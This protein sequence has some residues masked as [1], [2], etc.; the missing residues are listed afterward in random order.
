MK[1]SGG[2]RSALRHRD[3]RL[4]MI[5]FA[6]SAAGSWAYNV[7]LAVYV[8]EQTKSP[9]WVGA[10]TLARLIPALIAGFYGGVIAERFERVR[11]MVVL[12]LLS[13][14]M[15]I[16]LAVA[17]F[18][19][20]PVLLV[21]VIAPITSIIGTAYE[22][23][24]AAITPQV[25]SE[26]DLAAANALRNVVDNLAV[27]AGPAIGVL[28]LLLGPPALGFAV[29]AVSFAISALVVARVRTRSRPVDVTEDGTI[30]P[31]GQMLVGFRTIR[32]SSAATILVAYSVVA[33]FVY[34]VDTVLFVVLSQQQL[35]TGPDGF[36]Y[37]LAGLGAGGVLAAAAVSRLSERP[38][39]GWI[40]LAG[41]AVY[42][43]PTLAFL[44]V[45]Q[46]AVGFALQVIRGAGTLVVDVL[47]I[48]ALQRTMP[49]DAMARVFGA[50]DSLMVGAIALGALLTPLVLAAAGLDT[51]LIVSGL[52]VPV[53]CVI[54]WPRLRRMDEA[55]AAQIAEL[56]PR[57]LLLERVPILAE[58]PRG[59]IERL[60]RAA[61]EIEVPA[62]VAIV[63]EGEAADAF[64]VVVSGD[65]LVT[66]RGEGDAERQ[67]PQLSTGDYFG[68]IG[69]LEHIPRTATV[70]TASPTRLLRIPGE[71][72]LD[73]LTQRNPSPTLLEG[74]RIRL[75]RTH[76]TYRPHSEPPE[77]HP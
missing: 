54:G 55:D 38:R 13:A 46:P 41:M 18:V 60:A 74:A 21:L 64:F 26:R 1:K 51:A 3:F 77:N 69:L 31:L 49:S 14:L 23:A 19:E 32:S 30:G 2:L 17:T 25:V 62:G 12:D 65:V 56:A 36:G 9:A 61:E 63:T 27:I 72:F 48:T 40:I 73:A 42:C 67:L 15:M 11:L 10:A 6:T 75:A 16:T 57:V 39:L 76:P 45:D 29:N 58:A 44:V 47:A 66:A 33:T 7:A 70:T 50:F 28:L 24:V 22:P 8:Y 37:L 43:L 68:E 35:G 34:G 20:A 59:P 71:V 4:L 52:V 5:A 53:L